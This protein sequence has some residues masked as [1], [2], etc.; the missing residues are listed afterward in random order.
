MGRICMY[1][2]TP[3][4]SP[5][6]SLTGVTFERE[7]SPRSLTKSEPSGQDVVNRLVSC[8]GK[9]E[10]NSIECMVLRENVE[11]LV[12]ARNDLDSPVTLTHCIDLIAST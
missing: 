11:G 10:E 8:W 6:C 4:S 1:L 12:R 3:P 7:V 9:G 5:S 2:F